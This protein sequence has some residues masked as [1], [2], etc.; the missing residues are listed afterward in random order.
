MKSKYLQFLP[1]ILILVMTYYV[2][3]ILIED[4][5]SA[6]FILLAVIPLIVFVNSFL[7][8]RR[9]NFQ[10]VLVVLAMALFV[11]SIFMY[12]NATALVYTFW[13]GF[14][15]AAGCFAGAFLN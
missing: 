10:W 15:A 7:C 5:G 9:H 1:Y 6:M 11:P 14:I 8:G 2:L 13:Y 12:Y 4:T 3:P